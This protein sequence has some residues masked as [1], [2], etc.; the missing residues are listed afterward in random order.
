MHQAH[1]GLKNKKA[2]KK[3]TSLA[4]VKCCLFSATMFVIIV[5]ADTRDFQNGLDHDRD[6]C[7]QNG[8]DWSE[9]EDT[10][11]CRQKRVQR[12]D[13]E[14][15]AG[16][17]RL[18]NLT[19][20]HKNDVQQSDL[21]SQ[22]CVPEQQMDHRPR[23]HYHPAPQNRDEIE[24]RDSQSLQEPKIDAEVHE[25]QTQQDKT[26]C[27][28]LDR[29]YD[30]SLQALS[31]CVDDFFDIIADR[32]HFNPSLSLYTFSIH[33]RAPAKHRPLVGFFPVPLEASRLTADAI[34]MV[35]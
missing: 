33:A 6:H 2:R 5:S 24:N 11:D 29:R 23:D 31:G 8:S 30:V 27:S 18:R 14:F 25:S 21:P 19:N 10:N 12:P 16:N 7:S 3:S 1:K 4:L 32:I 17:E 15:L 20:N 22:R 9:Q 26:D 35:L 34:R 13:A 28:K